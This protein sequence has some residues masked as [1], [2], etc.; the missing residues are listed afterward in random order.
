M[1]VDVADIERWFSGILSPPPP[2]AFESW[3]F[4]IASGLLGMFAEAFKAAYWAGVKD[5][6]FLCVPI[7][8]IVA[9]VSFVVGVVLTICVL[10]MLGC[11]RHERPSQINAPVVAGLPPL[12]DP[13]SRAGRA[14]GM[15]QRLD[16]PG[17]GSD[18]G[19]PW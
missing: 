16:L 5:A 13:D 10:A 14:D 2:P 7:V 6:I 3:P 8:I 19:P 11:F 4:R 17:R 12:R 18:G 15:G 1:D 9:F